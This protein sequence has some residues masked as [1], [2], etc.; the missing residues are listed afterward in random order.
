MS[1]H[2]LLGL[3][4]ILIVGIGARWIAWRLH[5]PSILLLLICGIV[6][7]PVTGFLDPDELFGELL[8]PIVSLSVGII[9]FEGG[10]SLSIRDLRAVGGVVRN[11]V[12][13]GVLVT[14]VLTAAAVHWIIGLEWILA[15]LFGAILVVTG[16]T[17]IIPL[18]R[19]VRPSGQVRT[20]VKWEGILNDPIGALLAVLVFE[21]V[22]AGGFTGQADEAASLF[23]SSILIGCVVGVVF[24]A[25]MLV[26]LKFYLLPDF[27]QNAFSLTMVVSAF[28]V[29]NELRSESGLL[30]TT[31]MGIALANQRISPVKHIVEFKENL[32]VLIISSLFIILAAKLDLNDLYEISVPGFFFLLVLIFVIRPAA[33]WISCL[34][35]NVKRPERIFLAWMAPRGIVA[36]AVSSIFAARLV[37]A[38]YEDAG[39]FIPLAFFVIIGTVAVYGLSAFTVAKRLNLAEPEPQGVLFV[40]AQ[41]W[42]RR[43]ALAL[44]DAGFAVALVDSNR[45]HI[46][47]ARLEGLKAHYGEI[48]SEH[49]L[50]EIDLY[51]VGKLLAVTP[52]E[53]ANSLAA[54]HFSEIFGRKEVYQLAPDPGDLGPRRSLSVHHLNGRLAFSNTLGHGGFEERFRDGAE[55]KS[56]NLSEKFDYAAFQSRYGHALPLF[57][58]TKAGSLSVVTGDSLTEPRPGETLL[59]LVDPAKS[60]N[61]EHT[62]ETPLEPGV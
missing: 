4:S 57:R 45:A 48:L 27:L 26:L 5:L 36:A 22:L 8:L 41:P 11:L 17:V 53:E 35:S 56:T 54:L 30:A 15:V 13:L 44:K 3:A 42:A 50:D 38:G 6:A 52:N 61:G 28:T 59:A 49:V 18:L 25:L 60:S 33:V 14:W 20:I 31:V 40:G 46:S 58:I 10:L 12:T 9:L 1:E 55:L 37:E 29:S 32:R 24:A 7:G 2:H 19:H 23:F 16:P 39:K 62:D 47:A 43:I 21:L 34:G 51:G